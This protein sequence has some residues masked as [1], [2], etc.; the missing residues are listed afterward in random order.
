MGPF[1]TRAIFY[2]LQERAYG[3]QAFNL[4]RYRRSP[5][6]FRLLKSQTVAPNLPTEIF[7]ANCASTART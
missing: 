5:L 7:A 1:L 4:Q 3:G 2:R 6:Y